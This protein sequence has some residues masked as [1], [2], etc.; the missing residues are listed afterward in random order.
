MRDAPEPAPRPVVGDAAKAVLLRARGLAQPHR[1]EGVDSLHVLSALAESPAIGDLLARFEVGPQ[2]I[3]IRIG[4][5]RWTAAPHEDA[6]EE[7]AVEDGRRIAG[8]LRDREVLPIHLLVALAGRDGSAAS[9]VLASLGITAGDLLGSIRFARGELEE[10]VPGVRPGPGDDE[11]LARID[12]W[13]ELER[14]VGS[15]LRRVIGVGQTATAGGISV[16]LIALELREQSMAIYWR[17]EAASH[18]DCDLMP[19]IV[20]DDSAGARYQ[21]LLGQGGGSGRV[22]R[23]HFVFVPAPPDHG[24]LTIEFAFFDRT[25]WEPDLPEEGQRGVTGPWRFDIDLGG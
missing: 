20:V 16:E 11:A 12:R 25:E 4:A 13:E 1:D 5:R 7:Q 17:S 19:D 3:E 9:E 14:Q 10:W 23:G 24:T 6:V 2:Q 15:P 8:E 22:L 18:A 21:G